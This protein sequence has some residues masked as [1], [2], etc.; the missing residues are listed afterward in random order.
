MLDVTESDSIARAVETVSRHVGASALQ[1]LVN[2]AGISVAGPLEM[3][4]LEAFKRQIDV[5][6]VGQLAVTKAFLP[7]LRAGRGR[8]LFMGS[9]LGKLSLP[10]LGAYSSAKYA[11]EAMAESLSME[12]RGTGVSVSMIAPGSIATP[13]W[14]K[15][16]ASALEM[17]GDFSEARWDRYREKIGSFRKYMES[18]SRRGIEPDRVAR[19]VEKALSARVPRRRYP[20]GL[21]SRFIGWFLPLL[22]SGLRQAILRA[23]VLAR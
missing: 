9:I 20:V 15:S 21:D 12:L 23:V 22:P 5:N 17:A 10:C 8:V 4:P 13:I 3:I 19:T 1:G 14:E 2:C 7:L 11:L 6:L 18:T 16:L